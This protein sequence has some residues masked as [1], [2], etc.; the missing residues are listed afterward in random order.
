MGLRRIVFANWPQL[1]IRRA[2]LAMTVA[3]LLG[4][5]GAPGSAFSQPDR[6]PGSYK[7][8]DIT[9]VLERTA[10]FGACPRYRLTISGAGAVFYEGEEHVRIRGAQRGHVSMNQVEDL[11]NEFLRVRFMAARD[12]YEGRELVRLRDG[13]FERL[14]ASTS[15]MPSAILTLRLGSRTKRVILYD[16]YPVELGRLP[17]LIDEVVNTYRW[18]GLARPAPASKPPGPIR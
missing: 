9:I 2:S 4:M 16:N 17:D 18:T 1:L 13:E 11:L 12:K 7:P 14:V 8:G 10:C 5:P 15:D 6:Y 3:A